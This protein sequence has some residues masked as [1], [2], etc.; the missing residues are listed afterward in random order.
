MSLCDNIVVGCFGVGEDEII[1]VVKV[2]NVYEF[3]IGLLDGYNI[4]VGEGGNNLLG[5]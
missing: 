1:V 2:V 3:I 4:S 5:G